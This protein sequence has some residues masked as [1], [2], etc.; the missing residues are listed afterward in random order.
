MEH[1]L[2]DRF[3]RIDPVDGGNTPDV[4]PGKTLSPILYSR[5]HVPQSGFAGRLTSFLSPVP[6]PGYLIGF[7]ATK[8]CRHIQYFLPDVAQTNRGKAS[9]SCQQISDPAL[10]FRTIGN[11]R[12]RPPTGY[13][14]L[15]HRLPGTAWEF[16]APP[17]SRFPLYPPSRSSSQILTSSPVPGPATTA[18]LQAA[19][20]TLRLP[21]RL[22]LHYDGHPAPLLPRMVIP[23]SGDYALRPFSALSFPYPNSMHEN[24]FNNPPL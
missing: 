4:Q 23:S 20:R 3:Y 12:S 14:A 18:R 1:F 11:D 24:P 5:R 7:A 22:R 2:I 13:E 15:S 17:C 10:P 9:F 6:L 19:F 8:S 16:P 21:Q